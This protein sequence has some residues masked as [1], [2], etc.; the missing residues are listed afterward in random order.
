MTLPAG[1]SGKSELSVFNAAQGFITASPV[2]LNQV[3]A[4]TKFR[5]CAGHD[6]EGTSTPG[7]H[8]TDRS[9][10]HYVE[11]LPQ[12]QGTTD[13]FGIHAPFN[14]TIDYL[15][16]PALD[17]AET[18]TL[19]GGSVWMNV[20]GTRTSEDGV[21]VYLTAQIGHIYPLAGL[22]QG[23]QVEAGQLL[24]YGALNGGNELDL[25]IRSEPG[26]QEYLYSFIGSMSPALLAQYADHGVTPGNVIVSEAYR[27]AHP[28]GFVENNGG[29]EGPGTLSNPALDDVYLSCDAG[30]CAS[31]GGS[32]GG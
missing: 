5:S 16:P 8:E 9:M 26:S 28:C 18:G 25:V 29:A 27:D 17:A 4:F 6:Y 22:Q 21:T 19:R 1:C 32:D 3:A 2:D 30:D 7:V 12:Y 23:D 31:D 14:G 11:P 13:Q 20:P 24:G 10:K 15:I